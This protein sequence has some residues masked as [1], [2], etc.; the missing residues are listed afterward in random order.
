MFTSRDFLRVEYYTIIDFG[1]GW[2]LD[3]STWKKVIFN[4]PQ[5]RWYT[6]LKVDKPDNNLFQSQ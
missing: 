5:A 6:F 1:I 3:L 4:E 2:Y